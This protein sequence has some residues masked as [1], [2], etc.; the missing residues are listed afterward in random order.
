[1]VHWV[2]DTLGQFQGD[3]NAAARRIRSG[4]STLLKKKEDEQKF[5]SIYEVDTD[6]LELQFEG[7]NAEA[8]RLAAKRYSKLFQ[9]YDADDL[10]LADVKQGS[11]TPADFLANFQCHEQFTAHTEKERVKIFTKNATGLLKDE[12]IRAGQLKSWVHLQST[13]TATTRMLC[14]KSDAEGVSEAD[15][16]E[17]D[18]FLQELVIQAV[19]AVNGNPSGKACN[20]WLCGC[21][22]KHNPALKDGAIHACGKEHLWADF[23]KNAKGFATLKEAVKL[24]YRERRKKLRESGK[25]Q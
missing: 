8:M 12:L 15:P 10:D 11:A 18:Q 4:L 20:F 13:V 19:T 9:N 2:R 25:S 7:Q 22:T 21:C 24:G 5:L 3:E 17:F 1:M 23:A 16:E 6:L 14:N